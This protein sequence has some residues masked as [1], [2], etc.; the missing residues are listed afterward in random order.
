MTTATFSSAAYSPDKLIAG[1]ADLLV[2]R[3][4]TLTSPAARCSGRSPPP[5]ST[6]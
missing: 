2:S 3:K 5:A 4:V 6:R 1:N